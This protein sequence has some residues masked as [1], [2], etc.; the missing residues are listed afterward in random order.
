MSGFEERL[1]NAVDEAMAAN[2]ALGEGISRLL[3]G[4]TVVAATGEVWS[5]DGEWSI[6]L[7]FDDGSVIE[8]PGH[9]HAFGPL[10]GLVRMAGGNPGEG[11]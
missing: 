4:R 8:V 9:T 10:A 5:S 2:E 6:G 11:E 3:V 1:S 7:T